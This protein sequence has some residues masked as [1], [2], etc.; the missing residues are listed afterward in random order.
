[1][2]NRKVMKKQAALDSEQIT[3]IGIKTLSSTFNNSQMILMTYKK[4][5]F[6]AL[7]E[8]IGY[9][10]LEF[11]HF[12]GYPILFIMDKYF[13]PSPYMVLL[14]PVLIK[15]QGILPWNTPNL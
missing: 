6:Y 8:K 13:S 5:N 15:T 3:N 4:P 2:K 9:P 11:N 12:F 7:R 10:F 14:F 1:M